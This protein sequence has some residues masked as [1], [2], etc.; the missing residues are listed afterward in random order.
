MRIVSH[1]SKPDEYQQRILDALEKNEFYETDLVYFNDLE[2]EAIH[3]NDESSGDITFERCDLGNCAFSSHRP[4]HHIFHHTSFSEVN[5]E[6]LILRKAWFDE[7]N[8]KNV[9]F[10]H[11][12][13]TKVTYSF[14]T[15]E[16]VSFANASLS[17][18]SF[19]NCDL[20]T[21]DFSGAF[22]GGT[23]FNNCILSDELRNKLKL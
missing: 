21:V 20:T 18:T 4:V 17:S 19:N 3:F 2:I 13:Q 23:T 15:F 8:L 7:C 16:N 1:L 12:E 22:L 5:F 10:S 14:S 9:N 11:S 6:N